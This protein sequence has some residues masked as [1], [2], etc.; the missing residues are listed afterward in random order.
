MDTFFGSTAST[1]IDSVTSSPCY[2]EI[3][4]KAYDYAAFVPLKYAQNL[5]QKTL[6]PEDSIWGSQVLNYFLLQTKPGLQSS[7]RHMIHR[8]TVAQMIIK[9]QEIYK[10]Q[11]ISGLNQRL[12]LIITMI[13]LLLGTFSVAGVMIAKS[14]STEQQ[15]A[16]LRAL[17]YSKKYISQSLA[18]EALIIGGC[19]VFVGMILDAV[20]FPIVQKSLEHHLPHQALTASSLFHS[21]PVWM[22]AMIAAQFSLLIPIYKIYRMDVHFAL[23]KI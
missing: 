12:G 6:Q 1:G 23:R 14:E 15:I 4:K 2:F 13:I 20:F 11:Q 18:Y 22:A 3:D 8:R 17:G 9:D 10:L 5:I 7:A 21:Y 16:I 19:S